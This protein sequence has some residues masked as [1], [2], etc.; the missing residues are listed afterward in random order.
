MQERRE[1]PR[2]HAKGTLS[3]RSHDRP[4]HCRL[5]AVSHVGIEVTCEECEE[6]L[7]GT[8][9]DLDLRLDGAEGNWFAGHGS[10]TALRPDHR[11]VIA[12]QAPI[13]ELEALI[14]KS[15]VELR[16]M[17][18]MVVDEDRPRRSRTATAFRR[19]GGHVFEAATPLEAIDHLDREPEP[20]VI[21]VAP[22]TPR[23]AGDELREYLEDE[24]P[25]SQVVRVS[26][27][28]PTPAQSRHVRSHERFAL[29]ARVRAVLDRFRK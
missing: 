16:P 20:A 7:L 10:V 19:E 23:K 25:D 17:S 18:V 3:F 27:A 1:Y 13:A 29:R 8:D 2:I 26:G 4:I 28:P 21:E 12:L 14:A 24:H 15:V 11:L 9:L 6:E 5:V 22:T